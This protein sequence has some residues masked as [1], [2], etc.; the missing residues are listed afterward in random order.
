MYYNNQ[1]NVVSLP[2]K[3]YGM[4][5]VQQFEGINSR[6]TVTTREPSEIQASVEYGKRKRK[7]PAR[8]SKTWC[9]K[10]EKQG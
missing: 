5:T 3:W 6:K 4:Y 2:E 9:G 7:K 1:N 10:A 8:R